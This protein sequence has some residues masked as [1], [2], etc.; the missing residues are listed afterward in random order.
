M[1]AVSPQINFLDLPGDVG[2][3]V[4]I[5]AYAHHIEI[6]A[7]VEIH[8]VQRAGQ[9]V[10]DLAA[11]H[12]A[13]VIDERED[14]RTLVEVIAQRHKVSCLI[15]KMQIQGQLLVQVLINPHLLK[16]RR[17]LIRRRTIARRL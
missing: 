15:A 2:S 4:G 3:F 11:Q 12:G 8:D 13:A 1:P 14:H 7:Q 17:T 5:D 9:T 6:P 10:E 16:N